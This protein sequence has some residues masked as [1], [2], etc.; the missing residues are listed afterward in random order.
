MRQTN[1]MRAMLAW[2]LTVSVLMLMSTGCGSKASEYKPSTPDTGG[3][4]DLPD[5]ATGTSGAVDAAGSTT[6]TDAGAATTDS[7]GGGGATDSSSSGSSK[8]AGVGDAAAADTGPISSNICKKPSDC[9]AFP[10][11]PY[12]AVLDGYCVQCITDLHCSK[13]TGNCENYKCVDVSCKP[14]STDCKNGFVAVCQA[15]GKTWDY[16]T[17][18]DNYPY[19]FNGKCAL[20]QPKTTFC[21]PPA[22]GQNQSKSV[23][24]CNETGSDADFVMACAGSTLC[25]AGKCQLCTPGLQKCEGYKAM[26]CKN[27]GSGWEV[28]DDCGA[29]DLACLGG[30]CVDPCGSDFKS[31]TAV[32]CDYWA[33]DLDNAQVPCG[34]KLC[35]AQNMQ[36]SLIVSNTKA[37]PATVTVTTGAGKSAKFQVPGKGLQVINLPGPALGGQPLNLDGTG[38]STN[39]YRVQSNV[40]IVVYQFNPLQNYEVFSNDASLL[41]PAN[42]LGKEYYIMSRQQNFNN[43]RGYLTVVATAA[44]TTNVTVKPTC[45][46]LPGKGVPGLNPGQ[47]HK[48]TLLQGEVLNIETNAIG[49]DLTGTWVQA[50]RAVAVFGG[51]EGSNVPDTNKCVIPPGLNQ[52]TCASQGWPCTSNSD[53]PVTCCA[54]HLEEQLI[55]VSSWGTQYVGSKLKPRGQ[56]KDAWRVLASV[57]G[58]QITTDPPQG[59]IPVLN[60]GQFFEFE[61][62]S[63]FVM[64]ANHPVMVGQFMASSNAPNPNNDQ[65]NTKFSGTKV[66]GYHLKDLGEPVMC[67]KNADCPN[68]KEKT[69]AKIGDPAFILSIAT[70]R[71]LDEYVVLV[72]DKYKESYINIMGPAN[73]QVLVDN[74]PVNAASWSLFSGGK[75]KALRMPLKPGKHLVKASAAV[76]LIV[77]GYDNYVSYGFPGGMAIK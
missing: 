24:K 26:R 19:C 27:D 1:P 33:V 49:A 56:E 57:D 37:K 17:C 30:L 16:K 52:G 74:L 14:G 66:C 71:Y 5:T 68:I 20:C 3:G 28:K 8:D 42:A 51:S 18:P 61:S 54:D 67:T 31:N 23:L 35:D 29:K 60:K 4:V 70:D 43:L 7:S 10:G 6:Q 64:T 65:C 25:I 58:T 36:Y 44:G 59:V 39:A 75:W 55:P 22:K 77:Y 34:P 53:C 46:T 11:T 13:S 21:A 73:A 47:T 41:L 63:D 2:G 50:D 38:I 9:K 72:P 62:K 76:G 15:D 45:K 32:G 12:C 69:D 48:V 40:P